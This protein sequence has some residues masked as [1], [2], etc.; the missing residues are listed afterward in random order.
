MASPRYDHA[1]T[2]IDL[3]NS[4]DPR[5]VEFEGE[6]WPKE[7]LY[8]RRMVEWAGRLARDGSEELLLAARAQHICRWKIPRTNGDNAQKF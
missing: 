5:K 1:C 2:R 6:T 3:A 7:V 8:S 4:Q